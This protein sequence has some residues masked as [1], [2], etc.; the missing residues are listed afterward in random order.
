MSVVELDKNKYKLT[1][2]V[3]PDKFEEAVSQSF[4]KNKEKFYIQG[5]R[6][7]RAPRKLIEIQYGKEVFYE[8]AINFCLQDAYAAAVDDSGLQVV[9]KPDIDVEECN[10]AKGVVFTAEVTVKPVAEISGYSGLTYGK[11]DLLPTEEEIN[12][13]IDADR[14]KNARMVSVE[15]PAET[16][17]IVTIDYKGFIDGEPFEGG[18]EDGRELTLGSGAF[19]E[20]FEGQLVGSAAGDEKEVNVTFPEEYHDEF[21]KGKP[22]VFKVKVN[23][24]RQK[25]LPD[26]DDEFAQDVSEFDTLDEYKRD[27]SEKI[28]AD[29]KSRAE[30]TRENELTDR[31]IEKLVADIPEVMFEQRTAQLVND[32]KR[33]LY[34]QG[35]NPDTY[36]QRFNINDE[37]LTKMNRP[38]AERFVKVS[39][40]LEAVA[41][42]EG[43]EATDDDVGEE[44][45]RMAE[46]YKVDREII[47]KDILANELKSF[48]SDIV[49]RKALKFVV[50][51]A[52]ET[53]EAAGGAANDAIE[54]PVK[55]DEEGTL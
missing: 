24:V 36:M 12:K 32:Y 3:G 39:L 52:V 10:A 25:E 13:R 31:L 35:M 38:A 47:E 23:D 9:S 51:N 29:K 41:K 2:E 34:M 43:I 30:Q 33:R 42:A 26:A 14:D 5:F 28:T 21:C 19:I 16:G 20:G 48:K 15:R 4:Q 55:T 46:D 11:M 1:F 6:K 7:G 8:D 45:T 40:A 53:E 54:E 22:A 50:D 37:F 49:I 44:I 27:I 17:D 18:E